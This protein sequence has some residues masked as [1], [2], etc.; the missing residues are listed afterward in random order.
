MKIS[1]HF[2]LNAVDP[3]AYNGWDGWLRACENDAIGSL[4]AAALAGFSGRAILTADATC[5]RWR[6]EVSDAL[7]NLN[8]GDTLWITHSGHGWQRDNGV[9]GGQQ[10]GICLYDGLIA[11]S[12]FHNLLALA[13]PDS[14]VIV[15]FDTCHSGGMDRAY[16]PFIRGRAAHA[17]VVRSLTLPP[18]LSRDT[19]S[20]NVL[21][22]AAC[23]PDQTALDG[24]QNGAWTESLLE[25]FNALYQE[26]AGLTWGGWFDVAAKQCAMKH[27][28]QVPA[29][30]SPGA[31]TTLLR[32]TL[33]TA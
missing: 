13:C 8:A 25:D 21:I 28:S 2:G 30:K 3:A 5:D 17:L 6:R 19:V 10:E 24:T 4:A 29:L 15:D 26:Q 9:V 14:N 32:A 20:A 1:L 18:V 27:P 11:D 33:V 12:E 23:Q 22:R 16:D 31:D 7:A